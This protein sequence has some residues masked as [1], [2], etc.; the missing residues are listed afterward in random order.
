MKDSGY[1]S[2]LTSPDFKAPFY[3][4]KHGRVGLLPKKILD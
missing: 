4:I 2:G 1:G 3:L